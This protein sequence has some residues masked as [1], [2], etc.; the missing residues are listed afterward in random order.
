LFDEDNIMPNEPVG[1][2]AEGNGAP[3]AEALAPNP[4]GSSS[5]GETRPSTA[6]QA[7]PTTPSSGGQKKKCVVLGTKRKHDKVADDQVIIELPLYRGSQ[8]P[9]DIV[10]VEHIFGRL[11]E[12]FRHISQVVKTDTPTGD[13]AQPS[14]RARALSLKKLLVPK[15]VTALIAYYVVNLDPCSDITAI[16]RRPSASGPPKPATKVVIILKIVAPV[17]AVVISSMEGG[18]GQTVMSTADTWDSSRRVTDFLES[19]K[20]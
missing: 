15:Y 5:A 14:K 18:T 8:S 10:V 9:L 7:V 12:A 1:D 2:D 20:N 17:A 13:D 19:L 11:F 16:H 6:D 3:S 4:I